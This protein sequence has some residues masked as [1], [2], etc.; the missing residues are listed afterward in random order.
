VSSRRILAFVMAGGEGSRLNPLTAERSKPSVPFGGRYRIVDFA[1]SNLINSGIYAIY[2]LVQYKSQELI[3]HVRKAWMLS[4]MLP[5]QFVTI[6]PPQMLGGG[7]EWFQG[8][9]DAV[10][11][12]LNLVEE[13]EPD[14]VLVFGADHIY[15]MDIRQ[16]VEFHLARQ[17]DVTISALPVPLQ[18]ATA[19]GV[20]D[21]DEEG[22]VRDFREKPAEPPAMAGR[23]THAFASMGNYLFSA[24]MLVDAL[25][26]SQRRGESDF[27]KHVLPRLIGQRRVYAY[28]F[29]TNLIPGI[30]PYEEQPYWRDVGTID[31]YFGAHQDVLG[32]EPR[33]DAFNPQ[34]PIYS[35]SYQGPVARIVEGEIRDSIL[36]GGVILNGGRVSRSVVRRE[37][38]LE[39]DV[40]LEECVLMDYVHVRRGAK[41]R[42]VIVDRYNVI[43]PGTRIGFDRA[44]DAARYHVSPGGV[45]VIPRGQRARAL[46]G[47][48]DEAF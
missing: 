30:R 34:W 25:H 33:F 47:G 29:A 5:G 6:V 35:S 32:R 15:R 26:E 20:I 42:R 39:P 16:M 9:A 3:E 38:V 10:L 17:A 36:A 2:L 11:Q 7:S 46:R 13:H 31:A 43:D 45:V 21:A 40:E 37:V 28:D 48:F 8:T 18:Q 12:N 19:F 27:G 22:R 1:L 4:P 14:L 41:L 23:P 24:D 44:A